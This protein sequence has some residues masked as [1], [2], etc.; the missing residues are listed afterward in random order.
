MKRLIIVLFLSGLYLSSQAVNITVIRMNGTTEEIKQLSV[1]KFLS[2][3]TIQC[4]LTNG[5]TNQVDNVRTITFDGLVGTAVDNVILES[6]IS[7]YPNPTADMLIVEGVTAKETINIYSLNGNQVLSVMTQEGVNTIN[8]SGL[9][10]GIY[11]L[12]YAN[13]SFKLIKE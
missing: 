13:E 12:K 11:L 4:K 10:N 8:V 3:N 5:R 9:P 1:I 7:V 6:S 2:G